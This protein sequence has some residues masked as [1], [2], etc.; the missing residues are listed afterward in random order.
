MNNNKIL[1]DAFKW[2]F[3]GLLTCFA[4]SYITT[5]DQNII[6]AVYNGFGGLSYLLYAIAEIV[7]AICLTFF[8]KKLNPLLAKILFVLYSILTGLSLSGI[9]IIYTKTSIAFVFLATALIFGAFAIIGKTTKID[10][11]KWT[12][13]L[14]VAL[15]AIIVLEIINIFL[16]NNTLNMVLCIVSIL[17][18]SAYVAYDVQFAI[19]KA[20]YGDTENIGIY[21]AF[22]LFVDFINLFIRLLNL[23]GNSDN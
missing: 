11:S 13:Y 12:V 4:I 5:L 1:T 21:C 15:L 20:S 23:F 16:A 7:I 22:Q 17:V 10:L 14:F 9:F 3:L 6:N 18:F 19:Q 8:I 2:L